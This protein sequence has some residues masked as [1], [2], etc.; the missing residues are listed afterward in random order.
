VSQSLLET[1][2]LIKIF[3]GGLFNKRSQV[4]ALQH[5]NLIIPKTPAKIVTVAGE[6]GSGKTTLANLVLGFIK[7]T[8]GKILYD[9]LD[10]SSMSK[11]SYV[12]YRRDVQAVFQDP[13]SVYNPFYRVGHIFNVVLNNFKLA[14]NKS[15]SRDRVEDA[16]RVVGI[17]G[18]DVLH[19]YPHQLS[20]GQLQRLMIARAYM[21][22]PKIIVADE[23]VSMIDVSLRAMILDIMMN[24][25]DA[26]GI[27]FIY[28]THDF[29]TA[30]QI[31]DEMYILY[32]G[33]TVEKGN[34]VKI[35]NNP[36]HTYTQQ[37]IAS[38][39]SVE[40]QW[41]GNIDIIEERGSAINISV[42]PPAFLEVEPEH[43]VVQS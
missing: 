23:P 34:T 8:S 1:K 10:V 42:D 22:K 17:K 12:K 25:R 5:F 29:S 40:K 28:I 24:L 9:N 14:T 39:P 6:S 15:D 35:I 16:L 11:K 27:S 7:P 38:I 37:L 33:V 36:Q 19:K 20:G 21:L 30:Y 32:R 4:V 41:E 43:W 2:D 26:H 3:S 13:Y 18:E 31:G